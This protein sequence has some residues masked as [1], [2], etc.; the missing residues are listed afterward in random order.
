[1]T[2]VG[3]TTYAL[4]HPKNANAPLQ[5]PVAERRCVRRAGARADARGH[6][7]LPHARADG[8]AH[9]DAG[10]TTAAPTARPTG[11]GTVVRATGSPTVAPTPRATAT[12]R[13]TPVPQ[14]TLAAGGARDEPPED[15]RD[16]TELTH[17]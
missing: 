6:A 12:L 11:V 9:T 17:S 13:G 5:P 16:R 1:M 2:M 4:A 3:S 14:I 15:H 8:T 10:T 7:P